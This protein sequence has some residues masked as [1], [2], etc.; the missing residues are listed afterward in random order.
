MLQRYLSLR[1]KLL[2]LDELHPYDLYV[3]VIDLPDR[4][5]SF[6]EAKTMVLQGLAPLGGQYLQDMKNGM[7][8]GWLDIPES[9]GKTG[10]AYSWGAYLSH[11]YVLLNHQDN[12]NSVFT[13]AHEMGHAMHTYYTNKNQHFINAEYPIFLAE[14]ASTVNE[15]LL[16]QSLINN[17]P[18]NKEKSWLLNHY[19][20]EFRGTIFRQVMFAEFEKITHEE[21][22]KGGALTADLLCQKY[23]ALNEK[24]FGSELVIDSDLDME[25][26][27]IPHFYRNFYV[28]QYATGFSA[29]ESITR[30]ITEESDPAIKHYLSFLSSGR[31]DYPLNLL[32]KAGVDLTDSSTIQ[33]AFDLFNKILNQ[34]EELI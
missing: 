15:S 22:E 10:G 2:G 5:I 6:E 9:Q 34:M 27:R 7:D 12:I 20:E 26:A 3:P 4:K 24:Y 1:K 19:L 31:S 30:K 18:D 28:Y 13:L 14:V 23:R 33:D 8:S 21:I 17:T 16:M 32:K 25:W 29:A 11:P